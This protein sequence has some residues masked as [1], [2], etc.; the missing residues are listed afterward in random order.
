MSPAAHITL[1]V[2]PPSPLPNSGAVRELL[3]KLVAP[4]VSA[5]AAAVRA[6]SSEWQGLCV[7]LARDNGI[8]AGALLADAEFALAATAALRGQPAAPSGEPLSDDDVVAA[9]RQVLEALGATMNSQ[10]TP[11]VSSD[12]S[13]RLPGL[14]P[15]PVAAMLAYPY[16]QREF[17]VT[18]GE[19][20]K[21][22]LTA[23]IW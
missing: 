2:T 12:G 5:D 18:F 16:S 6:R 19:H 20:S 11:Q 14:L 3:D 10:T 8:L 22:R 13:H 9:T 23:V 4:A 21:G 15:G 7:P 17:V 1:A